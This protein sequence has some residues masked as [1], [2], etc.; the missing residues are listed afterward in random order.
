MT[1]TLDQPQV[2]ISDMLAQ[3]GRFKARKPAVICGQ[4][5]RL[6]GDFDAAISRVAQG[7]LADGLQRGDRVAVMMDNSVEMLEVTFGVI[8]AGGCAVP[9]SGLLTGEQLAGLVADSGARRVFA[10][11]G[12]AERLAAVRGQMGDVGLWVGFGFAAPGWTPLDEF[13]DGQ[14]ASLPGIR[15]AAGD[16]FNIIY[17]SGTTGLP[18]GIVQSHAARLHFAFSNAIE[19]GITAE[20][21]TLTTTSLYSNGTWIVMLPT[22]FAGA[23]LHVMESFSPAGFLERVQ[24]Q[25]ITHSFMVPAQFIGVLEEP[26]LNGADLSS[27]HRVLCAGSPLRRDTKRAVLERITP[28]LVELYGFSEG[29]AS[30][31][32]P[33]EHA[34]KF[35]SVGTPVM[36]FDLRVIDEDGKPCP[37]GQPG[38]IV[39]YGAGMLREYNARPDLTADLIWRD[40]HGRTF[41]RSGDIGVMDPDGY[42]SI[43]DRKKDMIISGGF[44]VFPTDVEAVVG[45]HPDVSDVTVIGVPHPKWGES[46]LALVIPRPGST[47]DPEAIRAWANERLA[48]HQRLAAVELRAEFP[49]NALGKVLKRLLRE[50]YW[51]EG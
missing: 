19:L 31:L 24:A 33:H 2:N 28:G 44:N 38:E 15:H 48:K 34:E 22:L 32:K 43:V 50:P 41:I 36:G 21:R 51:A 45:G 46:C 47:A 37:A 39:G 5:T 12:F 14:P 27:L 35:D 30:M 11:A 7:L 49:R 3:H 9:L 6:W 1:D 42:L 13:A 25:R 16:D 23:T 40:E 29:F 8:R 17:S 26:A 20:A 4:T 18:K 10:S